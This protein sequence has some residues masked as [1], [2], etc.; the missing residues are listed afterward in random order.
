MNPVVH[1]ELPSKDG[2]RMADFYSKTF[3]W[4]TIQ[5][6]ADMG[7][8]IVVQTGETDEKGMLKQT[9]MINGGFFPSS[10]AH[11]HP[12]VVIAVDD[13]QAAMQRV[14]DGGGKITGGSK[15]GVP[16]E[17]P[18][19]GLYIAFEDTEGNRIAMLQPNTPMG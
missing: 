16:D 10:D 12:T 15:P 8:Y 2:P 5:M 17:I 3:G 11:H 4:N 13:I 7:D 14:K 9:N 18:G 1:F 19:I 6:G